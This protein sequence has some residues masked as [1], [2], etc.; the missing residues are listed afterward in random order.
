LKRSTSTMASDSASPRRPASATCWRS[1]CWKA[2]WL[3]R[4]VRLSRSPR[5][6]A[7]A[8]V[9]S[10]PRPPIRKNTSRPAGSARSET[11]VI[12]SSNS[13]TRSSSTARLWSTSSASG[14][15]T[16]VTG[17]TNSKLSL[18]LPSS[19]SAPA[20]GRR[21]RAVVAAGPPSRAPTSSRSEAAT[22]RPSGPTSSAPS[23]PGR[24]AMVSRIS[25]TSAKGS[26][27]ASAPSAARSTLWASA[28]LSAR[29]SAT[30]LART[31]RAMTTCSASWTRA[32][33]TAAA[34]ARRSA[35]ERRTRTPPLVG[36]ASRRLS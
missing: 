36:G 22:T 11:I 1:A 5:S 4:R 27:S 17:S 8:C 6:T 14:R 33:V 16:T 12:R 32:S 7:A 10:S 30:R 28:R 34:R 9:R 3:P 29:P 23:M 20:N 2:R 25:W 15:P 35:K 19:D 13:P 31:A 21:V 24:A 18:G 26:S